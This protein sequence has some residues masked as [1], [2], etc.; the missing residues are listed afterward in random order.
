MVAYLMLLEFEV[1]DLV[2]IV[3]DVRYGYD[4]RMGALFLARPIIPEG[5]VSWQ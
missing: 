2:T 5:V 3:E 1:M 4:R